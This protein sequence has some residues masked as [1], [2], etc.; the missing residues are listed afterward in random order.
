MLRSCTE[1]ESPSVTV[2]VEG[3]SLAA[4]ADES[5]ASVLMRT[6]GTRYRESAVDGSMRAPYCMMGACFECLAVVDG[7]PN[8]QGCLI[9]VREGMRI[10][11]QKG[12]VE[13]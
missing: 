1:P 4:G 9:T 6:F 5:V 13:P 8:R 10:E 2:V 11:R 7:V 12:R 3:R